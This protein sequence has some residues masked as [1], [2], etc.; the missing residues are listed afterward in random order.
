MEDAIVHEPPAVVGV[1]V[2]ADYQL[3]AKR[4]EDGNIILWHEGRV[5]QL[6]C[7]LAERPRES[8]EL[9]RHHPVQITPLNSAVMVVGVHIK[10]GVLEP[11]KTDR[12]LQAL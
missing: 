5:P 3:N 4:V 9:P 8:H 10:C 1:P 11:P 2:E 12:M 7:G 6:I